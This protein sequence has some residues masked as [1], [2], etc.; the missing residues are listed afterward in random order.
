LIYPAI[1]NIPQLTWEMDG[2]DAEFIADL[3]PAG[4][5]RSKSEVNRIQAASS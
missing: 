3:P 1:A 4:S 5:P 2:Q